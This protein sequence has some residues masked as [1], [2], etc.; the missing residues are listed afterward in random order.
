MIYDEAI[1]VLVIT[2]KA[3]CLYINICTYLYTYLYI[4]KYIDVTLYLSQNANA[5]KLVETMQYY[6]RCSSRKLNVAYRLN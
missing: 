3:H 5:E 2:G 6:K 1:G 4:H